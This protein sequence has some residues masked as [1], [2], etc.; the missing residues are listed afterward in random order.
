MLIW[1]PP[2]LMIIGINMGVFGLLLFLFV[3]MMELIQPGPTAG[4]VYFLLT[5][6]GIVGS[7]I[8]YRR[9]Q[10]LPMFSLETS[11]L[12]FVVPTWVAGGGLFIYGFTQF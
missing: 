10:E 5:G 11:T 8:W 4:G 12:F 6:A 7:D 9:G 3:T 1:R 2:A